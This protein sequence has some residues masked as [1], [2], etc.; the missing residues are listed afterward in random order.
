MSAA[1]G[2]G[3]ELPR[4]PAR[5]LAI[6]RLPG[7]Q[8]AVARLDCRQ[9][10]FDGLECALYPQASFSSFCSDRMRKAIFCSGNRR[11]NSV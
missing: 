3:V 2:P 6:N 5:E 8:L 4:L 11:G 10:G 1:C 7:A 9:G